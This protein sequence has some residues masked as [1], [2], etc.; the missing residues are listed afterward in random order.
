MRREWDRQGMHLY[1]TVPLEILIIIMPLLDLVLHGPGVRDTLKDK[2][3][4]PFN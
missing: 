2:Y 3:F 4:L 1:I